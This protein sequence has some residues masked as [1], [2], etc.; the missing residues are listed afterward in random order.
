ML[1][2]VV[3]TARP[4]LTKEPI[5]GEVAKAAILKKTPKSEQEL[6]PWRTII[7]W[8]EIK[9]TYLTNVNKPYY[10]WRVPVTCGVCG[11]RRECRLYRVTE[12]EVL[13]EENLAD[14]KRYK[15]TGIC[16]DKGH[17][18][19]YFEDQVLPSSSIIYWSRRAEG[20][21]PIRCGK[22]RK[23]RF[24][25]EAGGHLSG[26]SLSEEYKGYCQACAKNERIG[27]Q[28]HPSGA[29][30]HWSERE[31]STK[32]RKQ[33]VAI[34]CHSCNQRCFKWV[35]S[36]LTSADWMGLCSDCLSRRPSPKKFTHD[37]RLPSGSVIHWSERALNNR[38]RIMVT[39]GLPNC[40]EKHLTHIQQTE[41]NRSKNFT[42]FCTKHTLAEIALLLQ[43]NLRHGSEK[44]NDTTEKRRRGGQQ[45]Q[46]KFDR[47]MFLAD[48]QKFTVEVWREKGVMDN[49]TSESVAQKLQIAGT[50]ISGK[51]LVARL[52][53]CG[54]KEP[55][56]QYRERI[57]EKSKL[58]LNSILT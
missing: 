23:E 22:C 37:E 19:K 41:G 13:S 24:V 40:G 16:R 15:Y 47:S 1:S 8:P 7:H 25:K 56:P 53:A 18:R 43:N 35:N 11:K 58:N 32:R 52:R 31:D 55:W 46:Q 34:T 30:I 57:I 45:G 49:V 36:H 17:A 42:G 28:V 2:E 44:K 5:I 39:C 3:K 10:Q 26:K 14:P 6:K 29:T 51:G 38:N 12:V 27:D 21:V 48:T 33:K 54:I 20:E 9:H 4:N 50:T